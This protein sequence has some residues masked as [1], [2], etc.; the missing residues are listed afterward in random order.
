MFLK[1]QISFKDLHAL[2]CYTGCQKKRFCSQFTSETGIGIFDIRLKKIGK[3]VG[4]QA[5]SYM[6]ALNCSS[7]L[8]PKEEQMGT[9]GTEA[10]I[11]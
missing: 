11:Q 5:E 8:H 7:V 10:Q 3:Y 9:K 2:V 6:D 1:I 4:V